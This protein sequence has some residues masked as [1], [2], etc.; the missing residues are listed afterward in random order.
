MGEIVTY[1]YNLIYDV[2]C[3]NLAVA[4]IV[5]IG[6]ELRSRRRLAKRLKKMRKDKS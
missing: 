1:L 5:M 2:T 3:I 6:K 4:V